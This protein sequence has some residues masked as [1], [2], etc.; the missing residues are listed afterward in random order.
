MSLGRIAK[1]IKNEKSNRH[2]ISDETV[3]RAFSNPQIPPQENLLMIVDALARNVR[4]ST[5]DFVEEE[6]VTGS[7]VSCTR[8]TPP[9]KQQR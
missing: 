4:G 3:R 5:A 6:C 9:R 7:A 2:Q 8:R 1:E